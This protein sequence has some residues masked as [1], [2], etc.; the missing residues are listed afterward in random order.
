MQAIHQVAHK[1]MTYRRCERF[2]QVPPDAKT[3]FK[4]M[5]LAMLLRL[6]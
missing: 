1:Q 3:R 6:R 2:K 4:V 5:V